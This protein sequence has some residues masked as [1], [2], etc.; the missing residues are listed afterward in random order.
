MD[1]ESKNMYRIE[2][3]RLNEAWGEKGKVH[4][5]VCKKL[6][7]ILNCAGNASAKM[8]LGGQ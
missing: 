1:C 7:D 2:V 8:E 4:T 3:W 5:K 6:M